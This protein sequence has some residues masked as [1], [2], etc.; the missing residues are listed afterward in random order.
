MH[1]SQ[2]SAAPAPAAA[3]VAPPAA[4]NG[5]EPDRSASPT[6]KKKNRKVDKVWTDSLTA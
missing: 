2:V 1:R 5:K 6:G 3:A 4:A